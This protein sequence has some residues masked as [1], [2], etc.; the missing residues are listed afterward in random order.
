MCILLDKFLIEKEIASDK[1]RPHEIRQ[2]EPLLFN[3]SALQQ[4][5]ER[6]NT[7]LEQQEIKKLTAAEK[8][9]AKE[10]LKKAKKKLKAKS[11]DGKRNSLIFA[12]QSDPVPLFM[13]KCISFIEEN[14]LDLEGL[15][16]VPGNRSQVDYLFEK[17]NDGKFNFKSLKR[18]RTSFQGNGILR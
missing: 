5:Q 14:G 9:K 2:Q 4:Q 17:F 3:E 10:E 12:A 15:Y 8:K 13:L 6:S 1:M 16:R 11:K 7:K 18:T